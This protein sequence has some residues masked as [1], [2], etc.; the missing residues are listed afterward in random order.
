MFKLFNYK[1]K[2]FM[3]QFK[4]KY[5]DVSSLMG[6]QKQT[7]TECFCVLKSGFCAAV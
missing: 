3:H 7:E 2:G 6:R 4:R 1:Q 5:L